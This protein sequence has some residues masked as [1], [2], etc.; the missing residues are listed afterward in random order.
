MGFSVDGRQYSIDALIKDGASRWSVYAR[1]TDQLIERNRVPVL[2]GGWTS[3]SRKAML[4][5]VDLKNLCFFILLIMRV[6]NARKISF[7]QA[8]RLVSCQSLRHASCLSARLL[9]ANPFL[10]GSGY[11]FTRTSHA[12]TKTRLK[13]L[14]RVVIGE[15]YLSLGDVDVFGIIEKAKASLQNAGVIVNYFNGDQNVAF[16]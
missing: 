12:I 10:V 11:V 13:S 5:V 16:P 8:L 2:F 14:G 1:K 3:A 7:I 15:E 6:R 9:R 4:P